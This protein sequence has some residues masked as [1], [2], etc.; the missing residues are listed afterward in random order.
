MET[1]EIPDI[2]YKYRDWR[3]SY[4]KK[5]LTD[6][7]L[8]FATPR[9]FNDPFDCAIPFQYDESD[10]TEENIF[11][12]CLLLA[13]HANPKLD[14]SKLHQIAFESQRQGLIFD[15]HHVES[16]D[17]L[18]KEHFNRDFGIL[19]LTM[20][21]DNFLMWSHYSNS[22]SGFCVGFN[23]R[24]LFDQSGGQ[25]GPVFYKEEFPKFGLFDNGTEHFIKYAYHK[26]KIWEYEAEYRLLR[27]I[28]TGKIV[29]VTNDTIDE[30][31]LGNK[32]KFDDKQEI[33][34]LAATKFPNARVFDST[35]HKKKYEIVIERIR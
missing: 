10:L 9:E 35:T 18:R 17:K 4:N 19:S 26:S 27:P 16:Q 29:K 33:L 12:K 6:N 13:R 28:K 31:I 1:V 8:Y 34:K 25:L 14:E 20:K 2:L 22:H 32:M 7:E 11:K 21:R 30:I 24:R 23:S 15:E 5:V 3:N